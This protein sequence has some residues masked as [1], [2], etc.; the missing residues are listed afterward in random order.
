MLAFLTLTS[1]AA[2]LNWCCGVLCSMKTHGEQERSMSSSNRTSRVR[3]C[4]GQCAPVCMHCLLCFLPA[5]VA[6]PMHR[7]AHHLHLAD[8]RS[9]SYAV[10]PRAVQLL[11]LW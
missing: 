5:L 10:C 4:V 3:C 2:C 1:N 7:N 8:M 9:Q 11:W 6:Q